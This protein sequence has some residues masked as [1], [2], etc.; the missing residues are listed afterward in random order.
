[1]P[2]QTALKFEKIKPVALPVIEVRLSEGISQ[3][4]TYS[5]SRKFCRIIFFLNSV[6]TC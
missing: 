3:L 4:L 6:A 5:V 2:Y 1:M